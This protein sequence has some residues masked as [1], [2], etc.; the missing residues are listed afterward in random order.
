MIFET[1]ERFQELHEQ[2]RNTFG[3]Q[4]SDEPWDVTNLMQRANVYSFHFK[5]QI[6]SCV[7]APKKL[8]EI[9]P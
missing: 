9:R 7:K 1:L 2:T 8:S 5:I 4:I 6:L 3:I